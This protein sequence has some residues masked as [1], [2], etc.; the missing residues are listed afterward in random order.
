[1]RAYR[2]TQDAEYVEKA[3]ASYRDA[4]TCQSASV[5][6]RFGAARSWA[7]YA[8]ECSH[9]SAMDA[10]QAAVELLPGLAMLGSA[11]PAR[12]Q[13]LTSG[14]DGLARNAAA[15]AIRSGWYNKA[16]E[17]L[18]EGRAIFWSQALELR[19]PMTHLH[20]VAPVLENRLKSL[21]LA[22]EQGS[23]RDT[24]RSPIDRPQKLISMEQEARHFRRL[25]TE[26][27]ETLAEVRRLPDF[28]DFLR[29][30][31]LSTLQSAAVDAPVVILNASES[32]CD[33]LI[34]TSSDVKHIPLPNLSFTVIN[35]L[36]RL[37][38]TA[39]SGN[40]LLRESFLPMI[41]NLFRQMSFNSDVE[42]SLRQSVEGRHMK[43]V[44]DTPLDS[45]DI[46]RLVLYGLWISVAQPVI[47][48]L[49]L[50]VC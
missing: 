47:D 10:Y 33:A 18:E 12:Q 13:A 11:L 3:M 40:R 20:E 50:E 37:I 39:A 29:P 14:S 8:D 42:R 28:Q 45:E 43:R 31:R 26:W 38:Q 6:L 36:V 32:G 35:K 21:S 15:C 27:L 2:H 5:S 4:V 41:D 30:S 44:S 17:L 48:S 46:F 1:M 24:S 23:L 7:R 9:K 34:M 22:L 49:N 25:N 16:V 19:T